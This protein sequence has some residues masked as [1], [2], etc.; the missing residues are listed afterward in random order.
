[1]DMKAGKRAVAALALGGAVL[2]LG[3]VAANTVAAQQTP[4]GSPTAQTQPGSGPRE[5][6]E[7]FLAT[8]AAKLNVTTDQLKQAMDQTRQELGLPA[9][10]GGPG[11]PG[12]GGLRMGF[13]TAARAI[14]ISPDQLRQELPNKSLADV[15]KAHG[16]DPTVVANTLKTEATS[17]VDQAL[18]AGRIT[19]DQATQMKQRLN[20]RIDQLMNRQL[21]ADL[22]QRN[23]QPGQGRAPAGG[24][25]FMRGGA[26]L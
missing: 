22:P 11:G 15:A 14:G 1:M 5:R 10:P 26:R 8:L 25:A 19:A 17:R 3:G 2:A 6:H 24:E 9:G 20:D 4:V 12:H 7:Q 23:S 16:V 21:P 18:S 13:E